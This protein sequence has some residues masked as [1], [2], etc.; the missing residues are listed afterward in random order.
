MLPIDM[1]VYKSAIKKERERNK[2][3]PVWSMCL[4]QR[5]YFTKSFS[6]S[7]SYLVQI[8]AS[9]CT[10]VC[11]DKHY[12]DKMSPERWQSPKN[13][14]LVGRFLVPVRKTAYKSEVL[15]FENVKTQGFLFRGRGRLGVE[16]YSL[17]NTIK[18]F[19]Y[20]GC[21]HKT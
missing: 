14:V 4:L 1:T 6:L 20:V 2:N 13:N 3:R 18:V 19:T 15:F 12:G 5:E 10:N 9:L 7:L 17:Y 8:Y 16:I 21:P 11:V